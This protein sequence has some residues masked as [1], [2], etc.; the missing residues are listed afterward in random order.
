MKERR[1]CIKRYSEDSVSKKFHKKR[2]PIIF[3]F[4]RKQMINLDRLETIWNKAQELNR[5]EI[6]TNALAKVLNN[7][8]VVV[9]T[10][11]LNQIG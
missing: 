5:P 2:K 9:S 11:R 1:M 6:F 3:F 10:N 8:R 7:N 4:K